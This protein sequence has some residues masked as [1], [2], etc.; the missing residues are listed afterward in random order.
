MLSPLSGY[1]QDIEKISTLKFVSSFLSILGFSNITKFQIEYYDSCIISH[2]ELHLELFIADV[3]YSVADEVTIA[4]YFIVPQYFNAEIGYQISDL[5]KN[6]P[7]L[8]EK[9]QNLNLLT[10]FKKAHPFSQ[11]DTPTPDK[12]KEIFTHFYGPRK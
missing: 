10:S 8:T 9:V 2:L 11:P 12:I 3:K 1:K 5:A 4:D 6:F 7:L